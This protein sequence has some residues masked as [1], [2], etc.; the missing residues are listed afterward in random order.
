[1]CA[2]KVRPCLSF[3]VA[4]T[5]LVASFRTRAVVVVAPA[6]MNECT[7]AFTVYDVAALVVVVLGFVLYSSGGLGGGG[8]GGGKGDGGRGGRGAADGGKRGGAKLM[9]MQGAGGSMM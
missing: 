8:D 3:H 4:T 7:Q 5:D 9:P 2:K 6:G 1:M